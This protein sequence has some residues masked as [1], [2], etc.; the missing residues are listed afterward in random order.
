MSPVYGPLCSQGEVERLK[1]EIK[2]AYADARSVVT[3]LKVGTQGHGTRGS[4][5]AKC[6]AVMLCMHHSGWHG[7]QPSTGE[8]KNGL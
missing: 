1:G 7:I 3:E 5:A 8:Y 2:A 6:A 4:G